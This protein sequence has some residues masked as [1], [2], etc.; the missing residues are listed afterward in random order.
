MHH[1]ALA[2]GN[3]NNIFMLTGTRLL[4]QLEDNTRCCSNARDSKG[5]KLQELVVVVDTIERRGQSSR[6]MRSAGHS[7]IEDLTPHIC[8]EGQNLIK[9]LLIMPSRQNEGD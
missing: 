6:A 8:P 1:S 3:G 4:Q 7:C 5:C 2:L 9:V